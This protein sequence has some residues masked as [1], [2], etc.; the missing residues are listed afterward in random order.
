MDRRRFVQI[1]GLAAGTALLPR[2]PEART[3]ASVRA[4]PGRKRAK[5]GAMITTGQPAVVT[6]NGSTLP[7]KIV[8]GVKV[9][10]LIAGPVDHEFAPGLRAECWGY[11]GSTPGPTIEAMEGDR[12]R[13]YVANRLPEP[14]SVHWHGVILPNGMDG[15][16]GLNQKPIPPGETFM[17]EFTV[18]YPGTFMY[19]SHYDEMT[20]MAL[21]LVGMFIVHPKQ[22]RGPGVDRDFVLMT[23]EFRV[24]VGARRPDPNEM[25]DFNLL[26]FN[27]RAFPGTAPLLVGTGER[28]RIRLGNLSPMDHHPVHIHGVFFHETATDGG[29]IPESARRPETT[30]LVPVGST[31]VIE[32]IPEEPGDWAMH[33]HMTHHVMTQM[34]HGSP[35]MIGA[36]TSRLDRRMARVMPAYM[37]MGTT[38]MGGMGEMDMPIP[39][40][41]LPMRGG[42]GPFSYI[43]MGGM[44]TVL[45]VRDDP[46]NS[47]PAGWYA[48]PEGT[49]AGPADPARMKKDGLE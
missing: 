23:H 10:R 38:G 35:I 3:P 30:V 9:G 49:V 1:S 22:P 17:Y 12:L 15:V 34:G 14:T 16:A 48:H 40:N 11:N 47:D 5:P 25:K 20:Q 29:Y 39:P 21:G 45:K 28:V 37:T 43:D 46:D 13:I 42:P 27:S 41:S 8:D 44:F 32:L 19:H 36:D 7:W 6:P 33:C 4:A 26:T 2:N 24:A 18:K 31:R